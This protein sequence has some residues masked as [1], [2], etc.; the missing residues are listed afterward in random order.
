LPEIKMLKGP[1]LADW[2][3][4]IAV[5]ALESQSEGEGFLAMGILDV[6]AANVVEALKSRSNGTKPTS[7]GVKYI[8]LSSITSV[9]MMIFRKRRLSTGTIGQGPIMR[10]RG[11]LFPT[12]VM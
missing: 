1:P 11:I 9:E 10:F 3:P 7:V 4:I 2:K 8:A 5:M 12:A 6:F